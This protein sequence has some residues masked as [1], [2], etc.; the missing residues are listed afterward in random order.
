MFNPNRMYKPHTTKW[1]S[2]DFRVIDLDNAIVFQFVHV[3]AQ[4]FAEGLPEGGIVA[5]NGIRVLAT[6]DNTP[7]IVYSEHGVVEVIFIPLDGVYRHHKISTVPTADADRQ[8]S[9][10]VGALGE[11]H[12]LVENYWQT[13][14]LQEFEQRNKK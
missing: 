12:H 1:G 10:I 3:N 8:I 2:L 5:K 13:K 14:M 4:K 11:A 6:K 9:R 7:S